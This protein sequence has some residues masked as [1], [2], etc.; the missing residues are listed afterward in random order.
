MMT[1]T[2]KEASLLKDLKGQEQ[3][4]VDKYGKYADE[5]CDPELKELFRTIQQVEQGHLD[6]VTTLLNGQMP[7]QGN[8][9]NQQN[10]QPQR[11]AEFPPQGAQDVQQAYR[12]DKYLAEDALCTEKEVSGAYNVSIFEFR[13]PQV[14]QLLH[15]IQGAEQQHGEMLY[16]YM[17]KSGMY[18]AQ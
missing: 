12:R 5:A 1:W 7:P 15:Q 13:D 3:L 6:T 18:Q 16:R 10:Q 14:R 8:Q 9:Q 17:A 11:Y 4:C 2:Q